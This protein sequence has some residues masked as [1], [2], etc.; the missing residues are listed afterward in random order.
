MFASLP[1]PS[2]ENGVDHSNQLP[3]P[4]PEAV[5]AAGTKSWSYH[6][7]TEALDAGLLMVPRREAARYEG[8]ALWRELSC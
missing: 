2:P 1:A 8:K 5:R 3:S 7:L 6:V 4:P